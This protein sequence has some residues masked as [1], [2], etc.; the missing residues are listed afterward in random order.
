MISDFDLFDAAQ[1]VDGKLILHGS[2]FDLQL[3]RY[4][5]N[6]AILLMVIMELW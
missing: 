2:S 3:R 5:T 6:G 1:Q 4:A